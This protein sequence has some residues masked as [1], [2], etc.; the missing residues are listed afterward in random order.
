MGGDECCDH[1]AV[2]STIPVEWTTA[3][4]DIE[5]DGEDKALLTR[6]NVTGRGGLDKDTTYVD[7][8]NGPISRG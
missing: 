8:I 5:A 7:V 4:D 2:Q 3:E 1:H 6:R